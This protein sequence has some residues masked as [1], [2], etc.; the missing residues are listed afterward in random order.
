ML[1][2]MC[3]STLGQEKC[4]D[5]H[6]NWGAGGT[7]SVNSH[8]PSPGHN[9]PVLFLN[10]ALQVHPQPWHSDVREN[11]KFHI[12]HTQSTQ[13]TVLIPI[14]M[15]AKTSLSLR[16]GC[17]PQRLFLNAGRGVHPLLR[18]LEERGTDKSCCRMPDGRMAM[19][20]ATSEG[21]T[22]IYGS[23]LPF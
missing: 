12:S 9:G 6:E 22:W 2:D 21:G 20:P 3:Y 19:S 18:P 8:P 10:K 7:S 16:E 11:W 4:Y 17:L 23:S 5:N 13:G 15:K 1:D 14:E